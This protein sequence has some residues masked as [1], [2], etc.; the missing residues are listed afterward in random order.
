MRDSRQQHT[1][2][3]AV[4][5]ARGALTVRQTTAATVEAKLAAMAD[6]ASEQVARYG[7]HRG[8]PDETPLNVV[9][10]GSAD[11]VVSSRQADGSEDA[12]TDTTRSGTGGERRANTTL[13]QP[14]LP[15]VG[16]Q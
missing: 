16:S 2:D 14:P 15:R 13:S 3:R 10:D 11:T 8:G 6:R 12:K 5:N 1:G 7:T 4:A 9:T